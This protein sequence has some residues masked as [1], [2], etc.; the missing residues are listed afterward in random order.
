MFLEASPLV[1]YG[2]GAIAVLV[3]L[4]ATAGYALAGRRLGETPGAQWRH[5]LG[6][7]AVVSVWMGVT[8]AAADSGILQRFDRMP[9]PLMIVLF[10]VITTA[11]GLG[12]SSV[13]ARLA[14][15][16]PLAALVGFQ[17]FR[18]PLEL[19]MHQA[20]RD[21]L[22]PVQMSYSGM[23]FDIVTGASAVVLAVLLRLKQ[24]PMAWVAA[25]NALGFVL[26]LVVASIGVA[27]T[28]MI[29]AFGTEPE[30][31]NLWIA[32][33]PFV[34]LPAVMVVAALAG[35]IVIARKLLGG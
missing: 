21:S 13:G 14:H 2:M 33:F 1:T 3:A 20:A 15:G 11:L 23:N 5:F 30:Q 25:W 8:G 34:W 24:A 12:F 7:L 19:V 31:I 26:V 18:L 17:A 10:M 27:S 9:P 22:M 16:L 6:A 35:H 28:P 29:H 32:F 4:G